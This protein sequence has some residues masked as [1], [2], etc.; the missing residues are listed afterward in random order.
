MTSHAT[1]GER[2]LDRRS[3][4]KTVIIAVA[5]GALVTS[6]IWNRGPRKGGM[7]QGTEAPPFAL[8][9]LRTGD[10]VSLADQRGK[11][12]LLVFWA[13]WCEPCKEE[14]PAIDALYRKVGDKAAVLTLVNEPPPAV[15]GYLRTAAERGTDLTFPVLLD[16]SGRIHVSYAAKNIPYSVL[17]DR[18]GVVA[19]SF[20][21]AVDPGDLEEMLM[22]L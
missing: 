8:A 9:E 14:L 15:L 12:V 13:T 19:A 2:T 18:H 10:T 16:G 20:V 4:F 1:T 21:G 7:K 3:M 22:G 5:A 17:I 11:P 6:L